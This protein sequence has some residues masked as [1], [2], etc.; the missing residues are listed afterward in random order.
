MGFGVHT[1]PKGISS[2]VNVIARVGFE[3]VYF[4]Y[5]IYNA[6]FIRKFYIHWFI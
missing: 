5:F 2:K 6:I 4:Q 1:F 3:L